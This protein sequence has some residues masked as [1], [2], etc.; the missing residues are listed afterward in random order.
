MSL[1]F[2]ELTSATLRNIGKAGEVATVNRASSTLG[3]AIILQNIRA[4]AHSL[5]LLTPSA[6]E[7]IDEPNDWLRR[8]IVMMGR[9]WV[10]MKDKRRRRRLD[11][12]D[13]VVRI[14]IAA[15][16]RQGVP[17]IPVLVQDAEM[18]TGEELPEDIQALVRRNGIELSAVRWRTDVD[19]LIKE[20]DRVMKP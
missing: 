19:R 12:S 11:N 13:D 6:L 1:R 4:R 7:R 5:V 8:E 18:P 2:D 14:E 16:L 3:S 15:A 17:V 10:K 20:L 9:L